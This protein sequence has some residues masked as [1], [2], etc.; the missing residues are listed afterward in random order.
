MEPW[1]PTI[2]FISHF[3]SCMHHFSIVLNGGVSI[4]AVWGVLGWEW[5]H[6]TIEWVSELIRSISRGRSY[7]SLRF[8]PMDGRKYVE[9]CLSWWSLIQVPIETIIEITACRRDSAQAVYEQVLVGYQ[10]RP[11][12]NVVVNK[13][14]KLIE[15]E[16]Y[17]HFGHVTCQIL[18]G[19]GTRGC[20]SV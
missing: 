14:P 7:A 1:F 17:R 4:L 10:K 20:V 15:A 6:H 13:D 9:L 2:V 16:C 11:F 18:H 8:T 5:R 12:S 19:V 3:F